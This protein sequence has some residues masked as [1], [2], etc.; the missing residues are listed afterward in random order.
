LDYTSGTAT[1]DGSG[2]MLLGVLAL[3]FIG[4]LR[5]R[6]TRR[7]QLWRTIAAMPLAPT[8]TTSVLKETP[9]KQLGRAGWAVLVS[10]L[11]FTFTAWV[12]PHLWK[13]ESFA[14][15]PVTEAVNDPNGGGVPCCPV[16]DTVETERSRVR[17]YFDLGRGHEALTDKRERTQCMVCM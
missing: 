15:D 13:I 3:G 6:E 8:N 11:A 12:A 16:F 7:A 4:F 17:E 2:A 5:A 14:G 10:A 1:L 9:G